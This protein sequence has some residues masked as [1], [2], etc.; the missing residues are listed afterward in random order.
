MPLCI[1]N[2]LVINPATG[3][4]EIQD[5]WIEEGKIIDYGGRRKNYLEDSYEIDYFDATGKWVV[6]GLIDLHVHFR[7]PGFTHKETIGSGCS[8]ARRG[9]FTTVCCMPNTEPV[10]DNREVV[11]YIKR[12]AAEANGVSLLTVGAITKGQKGESLSDI[13]GMAEEGIVAISE[14]GKTVL[15]ENLMK[16][17]MILA[18]RLNL[19]VF[20]HAEPEELI[21]ERDIRLAE[22]TGARLHFCHISTKTSV[23]LI[24]AAKIKGINIT[25]ETAPHYFTLDE[26]MNPEFDTNKKMNPPLRTKAD[27]AAIIRGLKDGTLDAIATDHAPHEESEKAV[28]FSEAPNGVIGL[29]TSFAVSYTSLVKTAILTPLALIEKMSFVPAK[30]AGIDKGDIGVGKCAD[31]TIIDVQEPYKISALSFASKG[32]NTPFKGM[33]VYGRILAVIINGVLSREVYHD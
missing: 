12:R 9:G 26:G 11:G 2:G 7:E 5:L 27:V 4:F 22:E 30:I 14:D 18:K 17:A 13:R 28:P 3:T 8:A 15:D 24:R 23:D 19:P 29:E 31:I 1:S 33:T 25:A 21:V 32:R 16:K 20:S 10:V 6:P